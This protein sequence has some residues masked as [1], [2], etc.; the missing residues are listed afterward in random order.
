[1][2]SEP[3][4]VP[5]YVALTAETMAGLDNTSD[6]LA[7]HQLVQ[8]ALQVAYEQGLK[9]GV[10]Q[11]GEPCEKHQKVIAWLVPPPDSGTDMTCFGCYLDGLKIATRRQVLKDFAEK[12]LPPDG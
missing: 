4:E 1:M 11:F 5:E 10:A 7:R 2:M 12:N 6:E 8:H 9:A 3:H